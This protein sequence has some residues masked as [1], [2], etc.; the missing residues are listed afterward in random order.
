MLAMAVFAVAIGLRAQQGAEKSSVSLLGTWQLASYKYGTNQPDFTDFPKG[1]CRVKLITETHYT[2][3]E[4]DTATKI[5]KGSAGG[6]YSLSGNTYTESKDFGLGMDT[7][8]GQKH[9]YTIRVDGDKLYLSGSLSDGLKIEEN[10]RR[11]K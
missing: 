5:V 1:R 3:I 8:L 6:V 11:L 7:Y 10:W 4:Y 9:A 2:W